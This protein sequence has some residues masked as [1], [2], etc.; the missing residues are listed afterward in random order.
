MLY[1]ARWECRMQKIAK[2]LPS[3]HHRTTL[4]DYIFATKAGIDNWKKDL[5][6]SNTSSTC[7]NNMVNF[8]P[9]VAEIDPVV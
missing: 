9:L 2:K 4:L 5:L 7:C 6:C 3:V 1:A 8:G